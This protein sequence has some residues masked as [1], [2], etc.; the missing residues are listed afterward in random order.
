[1]RALLIGRFQPFHCGHLSI[2]EKI[3][4]DVDEIII[5]I[6]S[7]DLSHSI[8]NPFTAG[9]RIMMIR[10]A[11]TDINL[12]PSRYFIIPIT[13]ISINNLWP[14]HVHMLTPPFEKVYSGNSLV[15]RLFIEDGLEVIKP[16]LFNRTEYSGTLIRDMI[17]NDDDKWKSLVPEA[18]VR[19][20]KSIDGINRM[21]HLSIKELNEK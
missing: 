5:G 3:L 9:E 13:D 7:A 18:V 17:I 10:D 1:M 19:D 15:Q 21:K 6:G 16:T 4:D 11:L 2:V 14:A 8:Q 12:D 20:I